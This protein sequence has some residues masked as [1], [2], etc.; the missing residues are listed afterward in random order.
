MAAGGQQMVALGAAA[1]VDGF[2]RA[3]SLVGWISIASWLV[4]YTPQL[5]LCVAT[6]S[7]EGLS[8]IFLAIWLAGDVTNLL[9]AFWQ[10]LLPTMIILAVYYSMCDIILI[11]QVFYYRRKRRLYPDLFASRPAVETDPLLADGAQ[12]GGSESKQST[13]ATRNKHLVQFFAAVFLVIL[14]GVVAY[15]V[16]WHATSDSGSDGHKRVRETWDTKAQVVGWISAFLY[17]SSRLPQIIKNRETKCQGLSLLMFT[18]SVLGNTTYVAS[19][20]LESLASDHLLINAAWLVGSGGTIFLDLIVLGQ[21]IAY[22]GAR[23]Q[24]ERRNSSSRGRSGML[25]DD[26]TP[27]NEDEAA[28]S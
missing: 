16:S 20:L 1:A 24:I 6:Q 15:F 9:G 19:I 21:F 2:P 8:L 11:F 22:S 26:D 14:V 13:V 23:H 17:L 28:D 12:N 27:L 25:V 18:F 3:A 5:W 4:V 7:G 10:H